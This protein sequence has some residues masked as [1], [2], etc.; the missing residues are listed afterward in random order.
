[1]NLITKELSARGIILEGSAHPQQAVPQTS[2]P[3]Q[4]TNPEYPPN[5]GPHQSFQEDPIFQTWMDGMGNDS[6]ML[7][8][9]I[10][11]AMSSFEPLSVRVGAIHDDQQR[12]YP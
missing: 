9:E 4:F 5:S 7:D 12:S 2:S 1:M 8:P 6:G 11:E 10:F 3:Y